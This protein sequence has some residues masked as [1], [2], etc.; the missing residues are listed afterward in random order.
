MDPDER[1]R[2]AIRHV[3]RKFS[4]LRSVRQVFLWF[5]DEGIELPYRSLHTGAPGWQVA[6]RLPLY[7]TVHRILTNPIYAGAYAYG[8]T[9]RRTVIEDGRK[10]V[11]QEARRHPEDWKVLIRDSHESYIGWDEWAQ[12]P[13]PSLGQQPGE[14]LSV[15]GEAGA[16]RRIDV[17][18]VQ[19]VGCR[20]CCRCRRPSGGPA[21]GRRSG[22]ARHRGP[23]EGGH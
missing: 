22:A 9:T 6:W 20:R 23:R 3:F 15:S 7:N 5:R 13:G 8:R 12:A 18:L 4:E 19:L 2:D 11:V 10:R 14:P 21:S 17:Y 16:H 1:V